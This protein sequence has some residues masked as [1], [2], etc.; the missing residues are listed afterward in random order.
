MLAEPAGQDIADGIEVGAAV[1][2][3]HALG[4]ACGARGIAERDGIPFV[5]RQ[6]CDEG[7]VALRDR[8]L[9]FEFADPLAAGESRVVDV[10][11]ERLGALHQ[12]QRLAD[13]AGKFGVD[14]DDLGAAMIQLERD[15]GRIEP[16]VE[17]VEHGAGHRHREMQLV[18]RGD[19]RQHRRDRIAMADAA[20]RE[21]GGKTPAAPIGLRP[22]ETTAFI[23]GADMIRIHRRGPRQEAQRR[24]RHEIGGRLV[25][26]DTVL[27]LAAHLILP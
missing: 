17:C 18:H 1:V 7:F 21:P 2:G 20:A 13:H 10:D 9:V 27:V 11:H 5:G 4:I 12:R 25:Q 22:G 16:N 6:P 26:T 24:Q 3:H 14:Q 15:R 8:G 19:V 23:D